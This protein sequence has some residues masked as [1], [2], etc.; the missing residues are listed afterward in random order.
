[1]LDTKSVWNHFIIVFTIASCI[2]K[3]KKE[4]C[5]KKF[6]G[7]I[8]KVLNDYYGKNKV[9]DNYPIPSHIDNYFV[10]L[11]DDD[12]YELEEDTLNSLSDIMKKTI[13]SKPISNTKEKIII[14]IKRKRGCQESI[15]TYE[16]MIKDENGNIKKGASY[17][18]VWAGTS[19]LGGVV[20]MVAT[21]ALLA[22]GA[23]AAAPIVIPGMIIGGIVGGVVQSKGFKKL[24]D[25]DFDHTVDK[26]Y[27][28]EDYITFDEDI[29]KYHDGSTETRRINIENYTRIIAKK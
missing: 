1:M 9:K 28:N 21:G 14:E 10:E 22:A 27:L 29:I 25:V 13:Y 7:S 26:N 12:D 4:D 8:L 16:R 11:G 15:K 5:A 23:T 19:T 2:S 17:F 3:K 24:D 20:S 18:G 6:S